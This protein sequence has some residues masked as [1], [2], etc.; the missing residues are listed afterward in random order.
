MPADAM[1]RV[2]GLAAVLAASLSVVSGLAVGAVPRSWQWAHNWVLLSGITA[3]LVLGA[4]AVAVV[5][6]RSPGGGERPGG[7][8]VR[9]GTI[10][11]R[12]VQIAATGTVRR[13]TPA[14]GDVTLGR[15][16]DAY[17]A[18][19]LGAEHA[20]TRRTYGRI[21]RRVVTGFGAETLPD[22]I[23]GSLSGSALSGPAGRRLCGTSPSMPPVLSD[24]SVRGP[25]GAEANGITGVA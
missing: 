5:R 20:S 23:G 1:M 7:S 2:A 10:R 12:T 9:V 8:L 17:L 24:D 19:L 21:L 13:I 16:V 6:A 25:P 11:A 22:E 15:A 3:G 18:T 4:V 14:A